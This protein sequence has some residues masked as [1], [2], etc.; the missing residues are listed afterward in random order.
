MME[1]LHQTGSGTYLLGDSA[2]LLRSELREELRGRV[3][4]VLTSPPFPL[5]EKKKIKFAGRV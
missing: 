1:V 5:N 2:E 4:L 3:Q